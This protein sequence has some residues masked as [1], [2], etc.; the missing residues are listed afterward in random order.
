MVISYSCLDAGCPFGKIAWMIGASKT[1]AF[2]AIDL[3]LNPE[4]IKKAHEH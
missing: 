2:T 3:F 4:L 1:L